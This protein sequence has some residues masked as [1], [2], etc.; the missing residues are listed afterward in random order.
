MQKALA[1][2]FAGSETG[3]SVITDMLGPEA[4]AV[5]TLITDMTTLFK[6]EKVA[7]ENRATLF[8]V[9]CLKFLL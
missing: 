6:N 5:V 9:S 3:G 8:K 7:V 2:S 4:G 1:S